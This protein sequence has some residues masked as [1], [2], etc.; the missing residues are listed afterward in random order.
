MHSVFET[1]ESFETEHCF[2]FS[3]CFPVPSV[4]TTTF[5]FVRIP[6]FRKIRC[7]VMFILHM[8][9]LVF[10]DLLAGTS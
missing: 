7:V 3:L 8:E 9:R 4:T 2:F 10:G 5:K 1:L 6:T